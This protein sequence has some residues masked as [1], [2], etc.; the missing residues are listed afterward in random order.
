MQFFPTLSNSTQV[1]ALVSLNY[2]F[3]G[4]RKGKEKRK[5]EIEIEKMVYLKNHKKKREKKTT[6]PG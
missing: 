2:A 4:Y 1:H 5:A 6:S 3:T